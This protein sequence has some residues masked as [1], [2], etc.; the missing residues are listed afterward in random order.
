MTSNLFFVISAIRAIIEM[1]GLCL[2]AQAAMY[3][4]AGQQRYKNPVYQLFALLT[5]APRRLTGMLLP[6]G[7]SAAMAGLLCFFIL[8]ASW[9]GLA[10][11]RKYV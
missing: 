4:L 9:L 8:F 11:L 5:A 7:A 3:V 6:A 1:L 2:M 10:V